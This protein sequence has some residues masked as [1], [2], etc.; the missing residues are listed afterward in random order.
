MTQI[1][2]VRL[3]GVFLLITGLWG[4]RTASAAEPYSMEE[5]VVTATRMETTEAAV[6]SSSTVIT[7]S[8]IEKG[9]KRTLIDALQSVPGLDVVQTGGQGGSASIFIRGAASELTLVLVDGVEVNDPISSGRSFNPAN[10]ALDNI[11]RI[12][13]IRGPQSTLY[14]SDAMGGVINIITKKGKGKA[15]GF[16]SA[17]GGSFATF[18]EKAG[19][20]G[21]NDWGNFSLGLSR[22]DSGGISAA[23]EKYGNRERDGYQNTSFSGRFGVTP[24][25]Q[26]SADLFLRYADAHADLDNYGGAGGDDPNYV[27]DSKE[28][29]TKLQGELS[30]FEGLWAQKLGLSLAQNDRKYRNDPD[31][32]HPSDSERSSFLGESYKLDWQH[33]LFLHETNTVTFGAEVKAEQGKSDY[34]ST[35]AWGPYT[36]TFAKETARVTGYYLQDEIK[37]AD[38]F[39]ATAGI[40]IDEHSLFG[41]EATYRLTA[42]YLI[43]QTQTRLKGTYGTG[44]KAPSLYQIYS[45][46][47]SRNLEA[48]KSKGWDIGIEQPLLGKKVSFG[49]T[50]F[51]NDFENLID[52]DGVQSKY[53]NIAAAR[54]Q[55]VEAALSLQ[56]LQELAL[57]LSYTYTDTE[58]KTTGKSLLRRP[59]HRLAFDANYRF[60]EK[61]NV[62]LGI[63]YVGK[64]DDNYF[65]NMTYSTTR[66]TLG[67]YTFVN[68][69]AS[70]DITKN[71]QLFS[72]IENLCNAEYEEVAGWGTPGIGAYGGVKLSF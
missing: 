3:A 24:T 2:V 31:A 14:G 47:G 35:S 28:L 53:R 68:L 37:L 20:S 66:V 49:L 29:M 10:F 11:E 12:E 26:F 38:R 50:H 51:G 25:E 60:Q 65:D 16:V 27:V 56:P 69:A 48:A 43:P 67:G 55:G 46:Y 6:G 36:E 52:F 21:G 22:T 57:R 9:Q 19:L 44:F 33:N 32:A 8:E 7:A 34:S 40:R 71:V 59:R 13:V 45:Q 4:L 70:Y 54:T 39:F 17:E 18:R 41:T 42:S 64:R 62:N 5:M 30:L 15:A 23:G 63:V 61:G 58:D 72:R 1:W